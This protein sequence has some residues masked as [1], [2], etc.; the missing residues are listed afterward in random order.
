MVLQIKHTCSEK[1]KV[2]SLPPN[3]TARRES[4]ANEELLDLGLVTIGGLKCHNM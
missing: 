1:C 3:T 2:F 4:A